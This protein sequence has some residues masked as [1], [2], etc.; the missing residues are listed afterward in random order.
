LTG[1]LPKATVS[2]GAGSGFVIEGE[3]FVFA[4]SDGDG[5]ALELAG[6][7]CSTRA[8]PQPMANI[9]IVM[10]IHNLI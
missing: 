5:T 10:K 8:E 1:H 2:G 7:A 4:D 6:G 3:A 9:A